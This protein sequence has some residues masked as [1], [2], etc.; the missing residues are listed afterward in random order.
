MATLY[1]SLRSVALDRSA[2]VE[3]ALLGVLHRLQVTRR[4]TLGGLAAD[5]G[6]LLVDHGWLRHLG[7]GSARLPRAY[8]SWDAM[9]AI[10]ESGYFPNT[11]ATHHHNG[12]RE[13]L[14]L[15]REGD[16]VRRNVAAGVAA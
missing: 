2:D 5:T 3:Q 14:R 6:G 15:W 10:N 13:S 4:S 7:G 12:L 8:W 11:P 9:L 1:A 16:A